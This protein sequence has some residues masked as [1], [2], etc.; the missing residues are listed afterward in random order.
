MTKVLLSRSVLMVWG[1]AVAMLVG[2]GGSEA[3]GVGSSTPVTPAPTASRIELNLS[4]TTI[5]SRAGETVSVE[6]VAKSS[7]NTTVVGV[8]VEVSADSGILQIASNPVT[9]SSGKV[10]GSFSLG[11]DRANRVVTITAKSGS[12]T[13]S[14]TVQV[15][16]STLQLV[17]TP[18]NTVTSA[19]DAV[20]IT[21]TVQDAASQPLNNVVVQ[22]ATTQGSLAAPTTS[23]DA[24]GR[25]SVTITGIVSSATV[26]ATAV[27]VSQSASI[28]ASSQTLP[29]VG[30]AG[31][32]I[33]SLL[34]QANPTVIGPNS[35]G[36]AGNSTEIQATVLGD[37]V[38]SNST[39]V[40]VQNARVRYR[41]LNNPPL[42][43]LAVD[44]RVNPALTDEAGKSINTFVPGSATSGANGVTVCAS[45]DGFTPPSGSV[46]LGCNANEVG[47]RFSIAQQPLF[48]RVSFNNRI[49]KVDNELNYEKSFSVSVTDSVGRGVPS[50]QLT[51]TLLPKNYFKSDY[52]Y[53]GSAWR[54]GRLAKG[55]GR[56]L[57]SDDLCA[58]PAGIDVD[59]PACLRASFVI[60]DITTCE[61]EDLN[62]NGILDPFPSDND[63]NK[64]GILWPG[65]VAAATFLN[66]ATTDSTGF[67][68]LKIKYG[69]LFATW[70]EIEIKVTAKV[71]GT[72]GL[73]T[74]PFVLAAEV[75]DATSEDSPGSFVQSPFGVDRECKNK[76]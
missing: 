27:N 33:K 31:V 24:S 13:A 73:T 2:C 25:A 21:A 26:T 29:D 11:Q 5:S 41:I 12:L 62:N 60:G 51:A 10:T 47:A 20:T 3:P 15:T 38:A 7:A 17:L 54:Q 57:P 36:N 66:N 68:I 53:V 28:N 55:D 67:G 8:P 50:V 6:V 40:P 39:G 52:A 71:G 76:N 44:T 75:G 35:N 22:F 72:E 46:S 9:D 23:T 56:V 63:L 49:E 1:A 4:R 32:T 74:L 18:S 34:L 70:V 64:D 30:P 37:I 69:Q 48:V 58:N 42:G 43:S 19:Q 14:G 65:Q 45:V 61:N 59:D 16:G